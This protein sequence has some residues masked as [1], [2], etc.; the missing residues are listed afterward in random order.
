MEIQQATFWVMNQAE[1]D[2]VSLHITIFRDFRKA[3]FNLRI[4]GILSLAM[5]RH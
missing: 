3:Y 5:D 1:N 4:E 2:V